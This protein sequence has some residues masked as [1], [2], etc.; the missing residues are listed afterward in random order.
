[1]TSNEVRKISN[2]DLW[3]IDYFL[4]EFDGCNDDDFGKEGFYIL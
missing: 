3:D 1:M 4:H 2:D